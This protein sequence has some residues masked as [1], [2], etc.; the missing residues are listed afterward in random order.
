MTDILWT[1]AI[2]DEFKHL[3]LLTEFEEM[4]L[5]SKIKGWSRTKQAIEFNCSISTIDRTLKQ[6][7][8]KYDNVCKYSDLLPPRR[9]K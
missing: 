3:A 2:L 5:D 9:Q 6:L 7:R 8:I 1:R 4:V